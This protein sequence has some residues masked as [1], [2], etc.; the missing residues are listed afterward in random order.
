MPQTK[1]IATPSSPLSTPRPAAA[2]RATL[3]RLTGAALGL[4][5][6]DAVQAHGGP[7]LLL[8]ADTQAAWQLEQ[9]LRFFGGDT[10]PVLH[11]EDWETLPYDVFS[12]HDDIVSQRLDVLNRLPGLTRG[13]LVAPVTTVLHRLAPPEYIRGHSLKLMRGQRL[14]IEAF[15][16]DLEAAGYRAV[17]LVMSHGEFAVRGELI[18]LYPMGRRTPIRIDLFDDEIE[19]LRD[20]DPETQRS[21]ETIERVE[22]MPGHEFPLNEAGIKDFRR[23]YRERFEGDPQASQIYRAV[24]E[25]QPPGGIEYYLPLFF[26]RTAT[27]FDYLDGDTLVILTDGVQAAAEAFLQQIEHRYEQLRH[28][29]ER[30]LLPPSGPFLTADELAAALDSRTTLRLLSRQGDEDAG[31]QEAD[32]TVLPPLRLQPR[33]E[34]PATALHGFLEAHP[35]RVLFAA[36]SAGRREALGDTLRGLNLRPRTVESWAEFLTADERLCLAIAPLPAGVRLPGAEISI[37]T[38]GELLGE[39]AQQR[40]R[41]RRPTRDADAVIRNLTDLAIGAPV[42]HEDHGVGRYHGLIKLDIAGSGNEAEFLAIEYANK[43]RLYVP[44]ASLHLI[45]RYTGASESEAPLHKLGGDQWQR[46]RKRA[47]EKASDA[48]AELLEINARRAAR[49][50]HAF[51]IDGDEYAAFAAAFPFEETPDQQ[52]AIDAVLADLAAPTPMDRVICGDVGFGKTEVAMRAAFA[53]V[54]NGH[55]VAVLVPTTLLAEQHL[56][57]FRDRF[58]DWPVR[59]E[60]LSRFR[61]KAEQTATLKALREGALDIV[62]GTHKLLAPE[63]RFKRLGLAIIDEEH[64]FG[65][66]HKERLK[67]LR[68]EVDLLTLTATPIPRTLNMSLSGLR[69]LSIIATPPPR[70][71]QIKTFVHEWNANMLI[72]ACARELGR[73][74]QI[75]FLHNEVKTIE[76]AVRDLQKLL[77]NARI[78]MAHGQ[79]RER[80]LEQVMLDFY[81]RRHDV[82]VATTIIE[83]GIDVPN[84]NTIIIDRADKLG[85]AQLHQLRGRVGRS[86]HRAYAYLITPPRKAMTPDAV[87]RIEAIETLGDLGV[88]FSLATHDL[89]IRGA[90]ELLGED[91]SGQI[92][93]IGFT[94]YNELLER[95]VAALKAGKLPELERPLEHGTEVDLGVGALLPDDYVN[96]V[97]GRLILYKRIASAADEHAL[98]ELQV[99]LIDRFGLLPQPAKNL[100]AITGLKLKLTPLGVRKLDMSAHGARL[101]FSEQTPVDPGKLIL[102]LQSNPKRYKLDGPFK[103]KLSVEMP[104]LEDRL[105]IIDELIAR[106]GG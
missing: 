20:F 38:E 97:H 17:T 98:R 102:L 30:P 32:A 56:T 22:L 34:H 40:R 48:A 80:E 23:R 54:H 89:E 49:Q 83:S 45:S 103:L 92:Q 71:H 73:G 105:K 57:N 4:A 96:D 15:R 16:R 51:A 88:G 7:A 86:H 35:D 5:A 55:Q 36:E 87:K 42:V 66:R 74:G 46:Q 70:R 65:V 99:E 82:L 19:S 39:R 77:P 41:Q 47:A 76:R 28:D 84:A 62:I 53:V 50:G 13:V 67:Q 78:G 93:E 91:Q 106:L 2:R 10:L 52:T 24:S 21:G 64:R 58:A 26:E 33:A 8:A 12:P 95:A 85:L 75:Y 68:A 3:T 31:E 1:Q 100:F 25:G 79:M 37:V 14:D 72:E 61:S 18:D 29:R 90:G 94:L 81:H 44:V 101:I 63:I 59:I 27:L 6:A 43:D 9:A 104:E 11:L 60:S 69:D